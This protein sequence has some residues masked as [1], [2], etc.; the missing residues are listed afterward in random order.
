MGAVTYP[1]DSVIEYISAH[2]IPVKFNVID[3]PE[4]KTQFYTDWTPTII[5]QNGA[6]LEGRRSEGFL[7]PHELIAE[8][9]IARVK[10]ALYDRAYAQ[11]LA[12]ADEALS[13]TK[14]DALREPEAYYWRAVAD[15]RA[16]GDGQKL[17]DGWDVV[18]AKFPQSDWAKRADV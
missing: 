1:A 7:G 2:F 4:V 14:G 18:I 16:S 8:L 15:Y 3:R 10:V 9:S 12:L 6:G 13:L 17:S 11:A 5:I